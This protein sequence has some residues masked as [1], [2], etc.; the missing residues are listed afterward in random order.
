MCHLQRTS[1]I[2]LLSF[3]PTSLPGRFALHM[4]G[5]NAITCRSWGIIFQL[6]K[7]LNI[8]N[9][10]PDIPV[11][12]LKAFMCILSLTWPVLLKV[13]FHE[14]VSLIFICEDLFDIHFG[15]LN[16]SD[17]EVYLKNRLPLME[18]IKTVRIT[19]VIIIV[20]I[21]TVFALPREKYIWML[22]VF[23]SVLKFDRIYFSCRYR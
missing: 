20:I 17:K 19:I 22:C 5:F 8:S 1:E 14:D 10:T 21:V 18:G 11:M 16:W 15:F 4:C 2:S 7:I 3:K 13:M 12:P 6:M 9:I 23:C